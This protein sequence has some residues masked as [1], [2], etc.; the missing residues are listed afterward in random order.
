MLIQAHPC[1]TLF[2]EKLNE[3][4]SAFDPKA[5]LTRYQRAWLVVVLT[6]LLVTQVF[7]WAVFERRSLGEFKQ[8]R[9]RWMF[10]F[11][12]L[13]WSLL[14]QCSVRHILKHYGIKQGVLVVDDTE[15]RRAKTTKTIAG[16]HKIKDKKSGGYLNGQELVFLLLVS[17]TLTFP[18]DFRFYTPDPAT[19][20]WRQ[21]YQAQKRQG[22]PPKQREQRPISNPQYP[23]KI[24]LAAQMIEAFAKT[25]PSLTIQGVLADALYGC[26]AFIE[27]VHEA[28]HGAQITS[29]LRANQCV[30]S[31]GKSISLTQY[32]ARQQG[33]ATVLKVRGQQE[34]P[35]VM[36][37]A[38]LVVKAQKKKRLVVAIRYANEKEYRFLV[39]SNLSWRHGDVARMYTL[40]WLIEVFI[41]DWKG[42]GGWNQL[43]KHQGADGSTRGVIL[44]LLSDHLLLLHPDQS[45]RFKNK[46]PALPVGCMIERLKTDSLICT[47][48]N[49]VNDDQPL[50]ALD[51]LIQA[52]REALP[53]RPSKK[54]MA[55][56]DL[57]RME[58]THSLQH[59]A[60]A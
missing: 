16:A 2:V 37:A 59:Y 56:L 38:R 25:F 26:S 57:G 7:C 22:I 15:K 8:S 51:A 48:T 23:S 12:K 41:E 55:G 36:L 10:Y 21:R 30:I 39:A 29:E 31:R 46:Q 43:T 40:R 54:H 47:V 44:S 32:F 50:A 42:H 28:T 17:D 60:T 20:E 13:P 24:Q 3:S 14:L 18:I 33:V 45:A 58:T 5:E 1:V 9:L 6:G 34:Q 35:V 53:D 11:G 49:V 4:L 27:P 19:S 52:L